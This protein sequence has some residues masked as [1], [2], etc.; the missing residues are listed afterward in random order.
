[1]AEGNVIPRIPSLDYD[2][3]WGEL[4]GASFRTEN[5]IGS[6][7]QYLKNSRLVAGA[8]DDRTPVNDEEIN[9]RVTDA[10]L[11][12]FIGHFTSVETRGDLE[13]KIA[14]VSQQ[15]RDRG[16]L[17]Q[18]GWA[19]FGSQLVA[20]VF[21]APTLLPTA[22]AVQLGRL[23]TETLK[24][25]ASKLALMSA[26]DA[27][28]TEAALHSTQDLRTGGES[29]MA[30][31]GSMLLNTVLGTGLARILSKR[32]A[33]DL[34]ARMETELP[35]LADG[36]AEAE[37]A[38]QVQQAAANTFR[39]LN[40]EAPVPYHASDALSFDVGRSETGDVTFSASSSYRLNRDQLKDIRGEAEKAGI[41]RAQLF[42][43]QDGDVVHV[44]RFADES[45]ASQNGYSSLSRYQSAED[46]AR[47]GDEQKWTLYRGEPGVLR[48]NPDKTVGGW[49]STDLNYARGFARDGGKVYRLDVT[50][51]DLAHLK[52]TTEAA[53]FGSYYV[54]NSRL[55]SRRMLHEGSENVPVGEVKSAQPR[56]GARVNMAAL[57]GH[58]DRSLEEA[59]AARG[60]NPTTDP[61]LRQGAP[62]TR[63]DAEATNR[64][65]TDQ[66]AGESMGL[67]PPEPPKGG[68]GNGGGEPPQLPPPR[69][70][71]QPDLTPSQIAF[72]NSGGV[73]AATRGVSRL[74][75]GSPILEMMNAKSQLARQWISCIAELSGRTVNAYEG[76]VN[77]IAVQS[78]LTEYEG[79]RA[80]MTR[81][82]NEAFKEWKQSV[83]DITGKEYE[84][85]SRQ[86][87]QALVRLSLD[88]P[89]LH[90]SVAKAG[91]AVRKVVDEVYT[92]AQEQGL[93]GADAWKYGDRK[94]PFVPFDFNGARRGAT[95]TTTADAGRTTGT[96]DDYLRLIGDQLS[97]EGTGDE[98]LL[99]ASD[100]NVI[101][102]V[103]EDM[104][105]GIAPLRSST[106][107]GKRGTGALVRGGAGDQY[108]IAL[109][110][111]F[112]ADGSLGSNLIQRGG[113]INRRYTDRLLHEREEFMRAETLAHL[114]DRDDVIRR[115]R[116]NNNRLEV[117][118]EAKAKESGRPVQELLDEL[119]L[120]PEAD[121]RMWHE[122]NEQN[123]RA[124]LLS[125]MGHA[126]GS[127]EAIVHGTRNGEAN[128]QSG[129]Y[130][131]PSPLIER[132]VK[133]SDEIL[134]AK[135][136]IDDDALGIANHVV[137][138][139]GAD[140]ELAKQFRR[141][142]T[143][144]E[145]NAAARR[146]PDAYWIDGKDPTTVPDLHMTE[147][148]RAIAEDYNS[149]IDALS[150]TPDKDKE[151]SLLKRERALILGGED[152]AGRKSEGLIDSVVN[153]LR[154]THRVNENAQEFAQNLN[155]ARQY[156]F[157][158]RMGANF[159]TN[160][161]DV[162][163]VILRHGLGNMMSQ[164]ASR[165]VSLVKSL[166]DPENITKL[167]T[168]WKLPEERVGAILAR[169]ARAAG[170]AT[171]TDLMSRVASQMDTMDPF[172]SARAKEHMYQQL[173][174]WAMQAGSRIYFINQISNHIRKVAYGI[175]QDR[176]V[177]M[178]M[179]PQKI[180]P[181]ERVWLNDLGVNDSMLSAIRREVVDNGGAVL[182][183]GVWH[184]ESDKWA[185]RG[186]LS[187]YWAVARKDVNTAN[188]SPTNL[189]KPLAM[190]NPIMSTVL[191]FW[192][193]TMGATMRI[194]AQSGQRLIANGAPDADSFRTLM[195]IAAMVGAGMFTFAAHNY[196]STWRQRMNDTLD[197]K[198]ELPDFR[199]NWRQWVLQGIDRSGMFGVFG[200][201]GSVLDGVGWNPQRRFIRSFDEQPELTDPTK[202][203]GKVEA[204]KQIAGPS[205]GLVS[206]LIHAG[207]VLAWDPLTYGDEPK[208]SGVK[209]LSRSLPFVNSF[210]LKALTR[211]A[212]EHISD[213]FNLPPDRR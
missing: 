173:P 64:P 85:F 202:K 194:M 97:R 60:Q 78:R 86:V 133:L 67:E 112:G 171:E 88:D 139:V 125:S 29:A 135:G 41:D 33:A 22:K 38:D 18:G 83:L 16:V 59:I 111:D 151:R 55:R 110:V 1:M 121:R 137:R 68:K 72:A 191:Q 24:T 162:A 169:E 206:D 123:K 47:K 62:T 99:R 200:Q 51:H 89:N 108:A 120:D 40:G 10:G 210:Y 81:D 21:D 186:L 143:V 199:D 32:H 36:R 46:F 73:I 98:A 37:F 20:G 192:S 104:R 6:A 201:I 49:Y 109:K 197:P 50:Q 164:Y 128:F 54:S 58:R 149:R 157:V 31:G 122:L 188:V 209:I 12:P 196:A 118:A 15:A 203:Y 176:V 119:I 168:E 190:H 96:V 198:D 48:E 129:N 103:L 187:D 179:E 213:Q 25:T 74:F 182:D 4:F 180:A 146:S 174:H 61:E 160:L 87:S 156:A 124:T 126:K 172:A 138:R 114:Q 82:F 134:L 116:A 113:L 35:K 7:I 150:T 26:M 159:I 107:A 106:D 2:P 102:G 52:P 77:P 56:G 148:R 65:T 165:S 207:K 193:F 147:V 57:S 208:R 93:I 136:W 158:A 100:A 161:T 8:D 127:W 39:V 5:T 144:A 23:G 153:Q 140:V 205:M 79:M 90:P 204:V 34:G 76:Q 92:R 166:A 181:H 132:N 44:S 30:V 3:T 142:M 101:S 105:T 211:D 145:A 177:R 163:A 11:T 27:G 117:E 84:R 115:A 167:A 141:P 184:V 178:A 152:D 43:K 70:S 170:I 95:D 155:A 175:F 91:R 42:Y 66:W 94:S 14:H 183:G 189:E 53:E 63:W 154:G 19:G 9:R 28:I 130:G 69:A 71:Y 80:I 185:D 17:D 45:V 131:R 195:G 75:G 13:R 212:Q